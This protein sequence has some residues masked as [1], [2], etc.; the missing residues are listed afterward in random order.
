VLTRIAATMGG[1]PHGAAWHRR[2]L[3]DAALQ[4]P[5]LRPAILS[6]DTVRA[7]EPYL[8]FRHRCRNLYLFDLDAAL[9]KPLTS[10]SRQHVPRSRR[11]MS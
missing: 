4:L 6:A 7:L 2:L 9:V 3:D 10:F 1:M 11:C 8:A 5:K